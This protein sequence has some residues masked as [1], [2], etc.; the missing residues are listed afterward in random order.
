MDP[1]AL[2]HS[3]PV[4]TAAVSTTAMCVTAPI[5]AEIGQMRRPVQVSYA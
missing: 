2:R 5:T 1:A 3:L 4:I